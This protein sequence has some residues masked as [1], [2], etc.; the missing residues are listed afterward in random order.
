M[1]KEEWRDIK[2]YEGKYMVSNLGNVK[3]LNYH[4][5]KREELLTPRVCSN[6]YLEVGLSKN[7]KSKNYYV[8]RLVAEA[9]IPDKTKFKYINEKDRLKYVNNLDKLDVNHIKEFEKENNRVDN[10]EWC[11]RL[12]NL[13]YGTHNERVAKTLS[14]IVYQYDLKGNFIK[15]WQSAT[16][17]ERQL[18]YFAAAIS[19]CCLEK[20]K[21]AYNFIWSYKMLT[22]EEL[23]KII[24]EIENNPTAAKKVYQYDLN[25]NLIKIWSST[26][27]IERQLGYKSQNINDCCLGK[28]KQSHGFFWSYEMLTKE[29]VKAIVNSRRKPKTVYQYDLQGNLVMIWSSIMEIERQLGYLQSN[30]WACC[31]EKYKT[32]YGFVWSYVELTPSQVKEIV[33]SKS[34]KN[35][36]SS[37]KIYQYDLE[38]NFIREWPS[39]REI[40]RQLGFNH[41]NI[42]LCC[43]GK[44]KQAYGFI[45]RYAG[46][47]D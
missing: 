8:H 4:R 44:T 21:T 32:V 41:Q 9:F 20:Q 22:K 24:K 45:W 19:R 13:M 16:E 11:T 37:K 18:G 6:E 14:I 30:I 34:Q 1:I 26:M 27:E 25:G 3:S 15:E 29:E 17:V 7:G 42:C 5:E 40:E 33:D 36:A 23:K 46:E 2:D 38:G 47:T 31:N 12:Y 10:L 39:T 43:R 35:N 28:T